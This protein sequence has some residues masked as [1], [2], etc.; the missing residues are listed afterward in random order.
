MTPA[1]WRIVGGILRG[2]TGR[3][4][5]GTPQ[6]DHGRVR[7]SHQ[8]QMD[9]SMAAPKADGS[10]AKRYGDQLVDGPSLPGGVQAHL[11]DA[12]GHRVARLCAA[13]R[14]FLRRRQVM[15]FT[16]ETPATQ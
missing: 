7:R 9:G 10:L 2:G 12:H 11:A 8:P 1:F 16:S 13:T 4:F 15:T 14:R 3:C 5:R 6:T